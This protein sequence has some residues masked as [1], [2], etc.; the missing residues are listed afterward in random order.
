[1][2]RKIKKNTKGHAVTYITQKQAM[3]MLQISLPNFRRICL[4]KGIYPVEPK[5][6]KKA[7]HGSTEPRVYFNRRDIAFLRWEPLIETFRKLRTH[8][9]RL[10]R[11]REKLDR[12]KEYRLRMT[13]PTYTL[14][15]LVRER[16]PTR[17]AALQDLTDS[18]NLIFLFSRLPRLTQFH[19]ALISLCRRFSVEFLHYVIAMRCIRKAFISIKGFYL[20]AVI[21]DVPVVW[22]IP[23]HAASHVPVGVEYRLLATCVEFDV[24]LVG[25]LLVNLYKQA[26]LL[27]PPKLNTQAINNP[28]S[29]YCS[30]ENAHFEFLASLSIPIKRFEEEK[31][32]TEQMD[33]LI[34]LQAID[35]SVTAAVNKQMQIQKIKHLFGGKRFFFN[36]EVP[37]EVLSVI[38]RSCGGDCSWDALSG[39]GATYTEDDD[40]IDF[41]IVDRPMH[42]MKA[43]RAYVQ[44]QWVFDSLNAGR[45]MPVQDYLP[46]ATLP[47]HLSPFAASAVTADPLIGGSMGM[48]DALKQ[49]TAVNAAPG[50]GAG[51]ALYRPPE[52]DYLAG[53]VSL[54]ETRGAAVAEATEEGEEKEEMEVD[55]VEEG[56]EQGED[57][58]KKKSKNKKKR[59]N[60][61]NKAIKKGMLLT[62][63]ASFKQESIVMHS[64]CTLRF[65]LVRLAGILLPI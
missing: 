12:D 22:V 39:P 1:M 60:K 41:Q 57:A 59:K 19:P 26:G 16:Y 4:L 58:S 45:L 14:H 33:N 47:P 9:M 29:A 32:D 15:Q 17:K 46:S 23:H 49:A 62:P 42:C 31:I 38:I 3:R 10:K 51:S 61:I 64:N 56:G 21:D 11:A 55:E 5:N 43:I 2:A 53:L 63:F 44:P 25:S 7:G 30:P 54:A 20:E 40:R 28:T 65:V 48:A 37:K 18:L 52:M 36:R 8:Q 24:T 35:D 34:E 6:I 27:Y 13:K 50:F